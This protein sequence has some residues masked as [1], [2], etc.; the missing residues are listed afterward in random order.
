[1]ALNAQ[2]LLRRLTTRARVRHMQALIMLNDLR[3]MSRAA[4]A[5]GM[6]QPAMTQ[7][8]AEL[9]AL[10]ETTLFLRHSRGVDPTPVAQ[11]LMPVARRILAAMEEGAELI[12][13]RIRRD[14]GPVR[15]AATVAAMG[16]LLD[17]AL[18]VLARSHP[19]VQ[20]QVDNVMGQGLSASFSGTEFDLILCRRLAVVHEGWTF[21]PCRHDA[22][23]IVAG[24]RHPLAQKT[25]VTAADLGAARWLQNHV[26]TLARH[27]FDDLRERYGWV[28][29]DEV[30]F[31]SR[32]PML[33]WSMLKSGE[34]LCLTPRS[35]AAAWL[36]DGS[37]VEL[38]FD[39][40]APLEPIGF[41]W[42]LDE[43]GP[44]TR[45]VAQGLLDL[46][47]RAD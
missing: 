45:H 43:A 36:L 34:L 22:A 27:V 47:D 46:R 12:A 23:I 15:V 17:P 39:V 9:E 26:A 33:I 24:A 42:K 7:L 31:I 32:I 16:G 19:N 41:Y 21:V 35:V 4:Q 38:D 6:T 1:M 2:T 3:S 8:V 28:E 30:Q 40:G 18:P 25:G 20:V 13:T 10:L 11:D 37:I 14:S 29:L 5:M 44:S